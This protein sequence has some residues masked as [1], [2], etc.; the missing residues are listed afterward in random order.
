[1]VVLSKNDVL[2]VKWKRSP[3]VRKMLPIM[4][5]D[6]LTS[7]YNVAD[8]SMLQNIILLPG[9]ICRYTCSPHL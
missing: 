5:P 3:H 4:F 8:V 6:I 7:F 1:M 9:T 2:G